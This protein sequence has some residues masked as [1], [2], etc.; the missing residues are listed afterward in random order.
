MIELENGSLFLESGDQD[1]YP[2]FAESEET[3]FVKAEDVR[4]TFK[5]D[6]GGQVKGM[7]FSMRGLTQ[8][9]ELKKIR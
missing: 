2:M 3:F 6:D 8:E 4:V 1:R 5:K 9:M 7:L